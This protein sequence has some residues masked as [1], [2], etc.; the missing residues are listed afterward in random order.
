MALPH[1][2]SLASRTNALADAW[3]IGRQLALPPL[4]SAAAHS[5]FDGCD[6]L[7]PAHGM[8][9][10]FRRFERTEVTAMAAHGVDSVS[11]EPQLRESEWTHF[12][13]LYFH[14]VHA[15]QDL[16]ARQNRAE[17]AL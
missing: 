16:T 8:L 13:I 11:G 9:R 4:A 17:V 1:E 6:R 12:G 3:P 15:R 5:F 2:R 14:T 7:I 10:E